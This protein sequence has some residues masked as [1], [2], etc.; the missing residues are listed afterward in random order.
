MV[1]LTIYYFS[2]TFFVITDLFS[3]L[4]QLIIFKILDGVPTNN[5]FLFIIIGYIICIIASLFYNELIICN[6]CG[7]SENTA[8]NIRKRGQE[9][10]RE[11]LK[12]TI[13]PLSE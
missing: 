2:P 13:G 8:E 3:P 5:E 7:L 11:S 6:F 1:F 9:E 10:Q 12:E 4:F